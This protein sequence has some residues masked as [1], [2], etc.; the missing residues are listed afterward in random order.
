LHGTAS[1]RVF[2]WSQIATG[3]ATHLNDL[4]TQLDDDYQYEQIIDVARHHISNAAK[5][6]WPNAHHFT[7]PLHPQLS[8]AEEFEVYRIGANILAAQLASLSERCLAL[9]FLPENPQLPA[10]H[11]DTNGRS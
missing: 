5:Q 4:G 11:S 3:L 2:A 10:P 9:A 1:A 8:I 6:L 7:S